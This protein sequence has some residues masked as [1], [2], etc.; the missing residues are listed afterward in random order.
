MVETGTV[1]KG[2]DGTRQ[3]GLSEQPQA[4][5]VDGS[6]MPGAYG[7]RLLATGQFTGRERTSDQ[8]GQHPVLPREADARELARSNGT[9]MGLR[10]LGQSGIVPENSIFSG[11][12]VGPEAVGAPPGGTVGRNQNSLGTNILANPPARENQQ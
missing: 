11:A 10:T 1:S 4:A 3:Y 12:L 9:V 8:I 6:L 5:T 7:S 2:P